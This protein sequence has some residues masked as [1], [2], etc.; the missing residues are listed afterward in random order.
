MKVKKLYS[1]WYTRVNPIVIQL[2]QQLNQRIKKMS[3]DWDKS[4]QNINEDRIKE[5][6]NKTS[7][8]WTSIMS[9]S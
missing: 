5:Q 2:A 9:F 3:L 7:K 4:L 6:I 1:I 8:I